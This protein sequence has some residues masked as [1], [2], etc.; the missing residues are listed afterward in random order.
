VAIGRIAEA[1]EQVHRA[2][3]IHRAQDIIE[4]DRSV[5]ETPCHIP[6][7]RSQERIDRYDVP[8]EWVINV[9]EIFVPLKTE[10][11]HRKCLVS[12]IPAR[13]RGLDFR[14]SLR[15]HRYLLL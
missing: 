6:H 8:P 1:H 5:E 4:V 9:S 14:N 13:R 3:V 2:V 11:P 15:A 7:Q 12:E 10:L